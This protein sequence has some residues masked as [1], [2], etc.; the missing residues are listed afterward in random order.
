VQNLTPLASF[1]LGGEIRNRTN[2]H[3]HTN[4]QVRQWGLTSIHTCRPTS[5]RRSILNERRIPSVNFKSAHVYVNVY[6]GLGVLGCAPL[7]R[8]FVRFWAS[9]GAKFPNMGDSLSRT[10]INHCAKFDAVSFILAEEIRNRTNKQRVT[11][12]STPCQSA[13]VDNK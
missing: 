6:V 5:T 12:I 1:I 7:A 10:P 9:G 11:N 13:C 3:T 4:K 2:T 8:R